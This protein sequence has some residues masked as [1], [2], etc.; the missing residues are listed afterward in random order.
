MAC[1]FCEIR[2]GRRASTRVAE[3]DRAFAI[4]D[5]HPLSDGHTLII[6]KAHSETLFTLG[7]ADLVATF[8]L[9][10]CLAAAVRRALAP[11]GLMLLQL[12]GAAAHQS[13]P[14]VHIHLVPRWDQDRL[15]FDWPLVPGDPERLRQVAEKLRAAL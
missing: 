5:I 12:N 1:V 2:D 9:T 13:I 8:R 6:P 11:Q 3:N 14:H 4:L 7:D 10:H 15:G